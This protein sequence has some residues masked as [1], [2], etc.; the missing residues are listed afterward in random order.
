MNY[1]L[2]Y[3]TVFPNQ[4]CKDRALYNAAPNQQFFFAEFRRINR[5]TSC[6]TSEDYLLIENGTS[7]TEWDIHLENG[8]LTRLDDQPHTSYSFY[9]SSALKKEVPM[10]FYLKPL[11]NFKLECWGIG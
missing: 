4:P 2:E 3:I 10:N 6:Q 11:K 8:V 7:M 1:G 5:D 9:P